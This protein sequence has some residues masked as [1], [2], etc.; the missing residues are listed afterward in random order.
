[1]YVLWYRRINKCVVEVLRNCGE[2]FVLTSITLL[3]LLYIHNGYF[4]IRWPTNIWLI[5]KNVNK[6]IVFYKTPIFDST[7]YFWI[8]GGKREFEF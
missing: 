5:L 4:K 7:F 8:T 3:K 2:V 6:F 1:M